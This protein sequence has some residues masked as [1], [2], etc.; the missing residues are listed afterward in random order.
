[1]MTLKNQTT[2]DN[3]SVILGNTV[4]RNLW[5]Y[6]SS[7]FWFRH[8]AH[9]HAVLLVFVVCCLFS[10][11][12][13]YGVPWC[14]DCLWSWQFKTHQSFDDEIMNHDD[15]DFDSDDDDENHTRSI[16]YETQNHS[17][18]CSAQP[19]TTYDR[20][21]CPLIF[22]NCWSKKQRLQ[23]Q[24]PWS[25]DMLMMNVHQKKALPST[26]L[27]VV[28]CCGKWCSV[29]G[30][31]YLLH[32]LIQHVFQNMCFWT[33]VSCECLL[34]CTIVWDT[35]K[36]YQLISSNSKRKTTT[37]NKYRPRNNKIVVCAIVIGFCIVVFWSLVWDREPT[38]IF[39]MHNTIPKPRCHCLQTKVLF[40]FS[41]FLFNFLFVL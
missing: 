30:A 12:S 35:W 27:S 39:R 7:C 19:S 8:V 6:V 21:R 16:Q 25:R 32:F 14:V 26:T 33:L 28:L 17:V 22:K 37:M 41:F 38:N 29:L 20:L 9:Y 2:V 1:M 11:L 18:F 36:H 4:L 23:Q 10:F 5:E 13:F 34:L 31:W 40:F 24:Q 15:D 3:G